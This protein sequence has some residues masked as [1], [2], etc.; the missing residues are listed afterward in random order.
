[1]PPGAGS[2][3]RCRTGPRP[4]GSPSPA[5]GRSP[6]APARRLPRRRARR[7][8]PTGPAA[9]A[10]SPHPAH[11]LDAGGHEPGESAPPGVH[12][13]GEEEGPR[14]GAGARAAEPGE[15]GEEQPGRVREQ[16]VGEAGQ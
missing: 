1:T 11:A 10:S 16:T 3:A 4:P 6:R 7:A 15:D 9:T 2:P 5:R 8:V 12:G 13:E 14:G